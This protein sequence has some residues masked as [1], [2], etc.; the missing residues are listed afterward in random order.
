MNFRKTSMITLAVMMTASLGACA[1]TSETNTASAETSESTKE[2][3][4]PYTFSKITDYLFEANY[5]SYEENFDAAKEY[6]SRYKL[7]GCSSVQNGIY[8]GRNYD[9]TYDESPEFVVHVSANEE[10][11][12]ASVGIASTTSI[13]AA[14][15]EAGDYY[16]VYEILPYC[17][18]DGINDAGLT[19]N[20]N[21]VNYGE[22]GEFVMKTE[23][24]SDDICPL[25]VTRLLLD[26][27]GSIDEALALMEEM[28]IYSLGSV[29]E[30]HWL[31]SGPQSA[32]DDTFNTVVAELIPDENQHYQLSVIDYNNGDFAGDKAIMTNFHLTDFDGT[33]ESATTHPMGYERWEILYEDYDQGSTLRGMEDL[34]KKVYYTNAYDI[35][36]D[37]FWYSD[38]AAGDLDM[39]NRGE[40]ELNGDISAAGAYAETIQNAMD[41]YQLN[42]RDGSTWHT[43]HTSVY[44]TE[45]KVLYIMPQE[46]G[47]AYEIPLAE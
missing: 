42:A 12:H 39:T 9:W 5:D 26:Q 6:C 36:S 3:A 47:F 22:K 46:S 10:G 27:A 29:E 25:M 1:D 13:T 43:V 30:T 40:A 16:D 21:V 31:I 23:D 32:E 14:D 41:L 20:I 44:D 7:G 4:N 8:R 11:R 35:W 17:T 19:V 24:T 45:N 38:Y 2:T 28:D 15:V 33:L 37:N 18:L 34:M